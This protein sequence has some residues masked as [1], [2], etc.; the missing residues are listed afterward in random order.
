MGVYLHTNVISPYRLHQFRQIA[1]VFPDVVFCLNGI[2]DEDGENVWD[3]HPEEKESYKWV[4]IAEQNSMTSGKGRGNFSWRLFL[5]LLMQKWGTVHIVGSGICRWNGFMLL[6]SALVGHSKVYWMSDGYRKDQV[7]SDGKPSWKRR[8]LMRHILSGA[9]V[10]GKWA[11]KLYVQRGMP[12]ERIAM[13]YF[14]CDDVTYSRFYQENREQ[15]RLKIRQELGIGGNK[16]VVLSVA[17]YMEC[18]RLCDIAQALVELESTRPDIAT[19]CSLIMVGGGS[20]D[21]HSAI[22]SRLRIIDAHIVPPVRPE[23]VK[24]YYAAAD[25]LVFTSEGDVWGLVVNEALSMGVPVICT[26]VIGAA[27]LVND[28]ENGFVV[29]PRAPKTIAKRL[30]WIA[31]NP[32]M[33]EQ[34]KKKARE[35]MSKWTSMIG[36]EALSR[37][38]ESC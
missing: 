37:L 5:I 1:E 12:R 25:V 4:R 14:S 36:V 33:F 34:M 31:D 16:I 24:Y 26:D 28:G 9:W 38:V 10:N 8:F 20:Y 13:Q 15:A 23:A 27:E 22:I 32:K 35:S 29:S 6:I 18:K 30:S 17:R 11:A 7:E 19:R 2:L 21:D 3:R